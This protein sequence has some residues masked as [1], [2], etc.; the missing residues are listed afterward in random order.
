MNLSY[1]WQLIKSKQAVIGIFVLAFFV[2][3]VGL[4]L[5]QPLKYSSSLRLL[6]V[7]DA[8][9]VAGDSY[10]LARSNE[11]LSDVLSKVT[12]STS[13]YG[14]VMSAGFNIDVPYFG[15]TTK[16]ISKNWN[17]TIEVKKIN[18]TGIISIT[19]Y[20]TKADQ[21]EKIARGVGYVLITQNNNYHGLGDK[22]SLK[23]LDEP[24]T[25]SWPVKPNLLLNAIMSLFLGLVF[26]LAY[27][28]LSGDEN[29]EVAFTDSFGE[30]KQSEEWTNGLNSAFA[31]A[32]SDKEIQ[33]EDSDKY[34]F[35]PEE[36]VS[37]IAASAKGYG[38][39]KKDDWADEWR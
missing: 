35:I 38:E 34:Q 26:G 7:Q 11:Y 33:T 5:V 29:D 37:V 28:Y 21:A 30:P 31:E 23:L 14:R 24:I 32:T 36:P 6:V 13:F 8:S 4:T 17:K 16:K 27:I 10:T 12:Y 39:P 19:A 15:N 22:V 18:N 9:S 20:H 3:G 25:S 2:L 1:F